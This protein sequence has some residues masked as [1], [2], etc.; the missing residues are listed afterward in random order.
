MDRTGDHPPSP[1]AIDTDR[2]AYLS[3]CQV[4]TPER[5]LRFLWAQVNVRRPNVGKVVDFGCGDGRFSRF[6]TFESYTGFEIDPAR[7]PRQP[8]RPPNKVILGDAF[9][10]GLSLEFSTC[11]GNPPYVRHHDLG[12]DWLERAEGRL[13]QLLPLRP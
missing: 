13:K 6:G 4:D 1:I 10:P 5:L 12:A 2:D 9:E 7:A 3:R 8:L 11:V